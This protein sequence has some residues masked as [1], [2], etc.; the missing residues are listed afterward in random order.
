M[1]LTENYFA[2]KSF[3]PIPFSKK[4]LMFRKVCLWLARR[5]AFSGPVV[6]GCFGFIRNSRFAC[7]NDADGVANTI[8]IKCLASAH[9]F[10]ILRER[11]QLRKFYLTSTIKDIAFRV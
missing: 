8:T 5:T 10:R 2:L 4:L 6:R 11:F 7:W 1:L 3:L 9:A